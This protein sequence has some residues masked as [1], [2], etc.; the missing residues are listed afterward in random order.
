MPAGCIALRP[1]DN[2]ICEMKRL[3]VRS[4][5]RRLG[6]GRRLANEI[7]AAARNEKYSCMRL[8]TLESMH[9]AIALYESLGFKRIPAYY[10]NPEGNAVFMELKL[11]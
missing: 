10:H 5:F 11:R 1:L 6:L 9:D 3:Y 2:E 4:Q 7:L 8:D